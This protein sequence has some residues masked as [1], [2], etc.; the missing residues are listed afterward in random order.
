MRRRLR[1]LTRSSASIRS[2]TLNLVNLLC[3]SSWIRGLGS[4]ELAVDL[5]GEV[6][7]QAAADLSW[8]STLGGPSLEVAAGAR[9]HPYASHGSHVQGA[10]E[11][12]ISTSVDAVAHG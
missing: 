12:P 4:V 5:A 2:G 6:A 8:G 11:T 3:L 7:L 9:V 1:M 10:V